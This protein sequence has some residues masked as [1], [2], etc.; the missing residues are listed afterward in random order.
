[1]NDALAQEEKAIDEPEL[2]SDYHLAMSQAANIESEINAITESID[3]LRKTPETKLNDSD[4]ILTQENIDQ[5]Q[6]S[7]DDNN[8]IIDDEM[9]EKLMVE[10]HQKE[11]NKLN[12]RGQILEICLAGLLDDFK[13]YISEMDEQPQRAGFILEAENLLK[14]K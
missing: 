5:I 1:L 2:M 10:Y 7:T 4:E 13:Y 14:T 8:G 9:I 11:L 6:E 3:V 12:E